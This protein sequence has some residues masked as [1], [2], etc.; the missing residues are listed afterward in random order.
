MRIDCRLLPEPHLP[1]L[2]FP[3]SPPPIV[4]WGLTAWA[5]LPWKLN[6]SQHFLGGK[7]REPYLSTFTSQPT[8]R[9]LL[10]R[11]LLSCTRQVAFRNCG[12]MW[13]LN[14]PRLLHCSPM[15]RP[16]S[17]EFGQE[18]FPVVGFLL[19]FVTCPTVAQKKLKKKCWERFYVEKI[20]IG[21]SF[22]S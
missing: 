8:S 6:T 3:L 9:E 4:M 18:W 1:R 16:T 22:D 21:G 13:D 12:T 20:D 19:F 14:V 15:F 2:Q 7:D 10:Q 5:A 17:F 11:W